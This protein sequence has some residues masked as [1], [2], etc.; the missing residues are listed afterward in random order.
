MAITLR[1]AVPKQTPK[2]PKGT[3]EPKNSRGRSGP[4]GGAPPQRRRV[5]P[6][7][8]RQPGRKARAAAG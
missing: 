2:R 5:G 8:L 3:E 7:T 1:S 4:T 6:A